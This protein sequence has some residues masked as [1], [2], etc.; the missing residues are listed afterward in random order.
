MVLIDVRVRPSLFAICVLVVASGSPALAADWR[1]PGDFATIQD[2]VY[3]PSVADGDRILVG[4]GSFAGALIDKPVH[5]EGQGRTTISSGPGHPS[6]MSQGFRLLAGADG[7]TITRL[8]FTVDLAIIAG[9][10]T[11][12]VTVTQNSFVNP[13]QGISAWRASGWEITHN[14]ITDL[15]T[16]CGGGIGI[17]VGD[18]NGGSVTDNVV[19]HNRIR[20]TLHVAEDDCGGYNGSGIVV[21]A[22]YRWGRLGSTQIAFNRIVKN[23]ISLVSDNAAVVDVVA[24]E[25]TEASDA[26]L[27]AHVIHDNAIGFNDFRGTELQIALSPEDLADVNTISR[28]LGENRGRG[29]R[30]SAFGP[31][32]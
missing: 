6:G 22:D 17:L 31:V 7:T 19:S 28:N 30:P 11:T 25:L 16:R 32:D 3:S 10:D 2:A 5:I 20:G 8:R 4:P 14:D 26:P 18:Y 1:V 21:Y 24:F 23:D 29:A 15:R 12:N 27:P 13:V 9:A